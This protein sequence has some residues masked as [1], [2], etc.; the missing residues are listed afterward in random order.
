MTSELRA[1]HDR[2]RANLSEATHLLESMQRPIDD[3]SVQ[4]ARVTELA[5]RMMDTLKEFRA[6]QWAFSRTKAE[7]EDML[8]RFEDLNRNA[9]KENE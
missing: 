9:L 4:Y 2:L 3:L 1:H 5:E 6:Q 7:C 8:H